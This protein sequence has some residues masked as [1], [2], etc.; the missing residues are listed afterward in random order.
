M[1]MKGCRR[2]CTEFMLVLALVL[3]IVSSLL[4]STLGTD[5]E[6]GKKGI[7][8]EWAKDQLLHTVLSRKLSHHHHH[9]A[10]FPL[11]KSD[12]V[13]FILA[14]AGLI[15][16]AGGGIGGGGMLVPIYILVMKFHTKMAIPLS[17]IT[18][19]GGAMANILLNMKKR[20]PLADRPRVDWDLILMMEPLTIGGALIGA[21]VN[22]VIPEEILTI[23]MVV[24]LGYISWRTISK[25]IEAYKIEAVT[26]DLA[27]EI[28]TD[29][30]GMLKGSTL[31]SP[32]K[33]YGSMSDIDSVSES[34]FPLLTEREPSIVELPSIHNDRSLMGDYF[35]SPKDMYENGEQPQNYLPEKQQETGRRGHTLKIIIDEE[36]SI[37]LGKVCVSI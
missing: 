10:F 11:V 7:G 4:I 16:S 14:S 1:M 27:V 8:N 12:V 26:K 22:K 33:P 25:G 31:K 13:G 35:P 9:K 20:H 18:V 34:A 37:P 36:R 21:L 24:L 32:T 2:R 5:E 17:N 15:I 23:L 6:E 29:R 19:L 28:E 30:N 3:T